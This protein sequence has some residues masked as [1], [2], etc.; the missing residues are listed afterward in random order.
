MNT[1]ELEVVWNQAVEDTLIF[2]ETWWK[3]DWDQTTSKLIVTKVNNSD[4]YKGY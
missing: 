3:I 2:G 1:E 4:V